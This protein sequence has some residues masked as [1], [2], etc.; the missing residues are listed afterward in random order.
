MNNFSACN[1]CGR[2][3][4]VESDLLSVD[5]GGDCWGCVGEAEIGGELTSK[6]EQEIASGLRNADGSAADR[7]AG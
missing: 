7:S 3:L 6:V 4:N 1:I 2:P 5:C